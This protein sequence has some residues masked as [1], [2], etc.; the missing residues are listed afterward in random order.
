MVRYSFLEPVLLRKAF[1]DP[2][3]PDEICW[4]PRDVRAAINALTEHRQTIGAL[5]VYFRER[6]QVYCPVWGD[7]LMLPG[8]NTAYLRLFDGLNLD[9]QVTL[10]FVYQLVARFALVRPG[11]YD[12]TADRAH[13]KEGI[14]SETSNYDLQ[15]I[16]FCLQLN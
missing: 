14:A 13:V 6:D 15:G 4:K 1:F 5:S 16:Y 11:D 3:R 7:C 9:Q 12:W 8:G 10:D 2:L